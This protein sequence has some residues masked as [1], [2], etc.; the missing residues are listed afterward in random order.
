MSR[1]LEAWSSCL[2]LSRDRKWEL[3]ASGSYLSVGERMG[4]GMREEGKEWRE[5]KSDPNA[6]LVPSL[7]PSPHAPHLPVRNGLVNKVKFLGLV[8]QK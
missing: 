6:S 4:G 5:E 2:L 3:S 8:T 7:V 1:D